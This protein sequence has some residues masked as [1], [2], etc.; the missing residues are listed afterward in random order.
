MIEKKNISSVEVAALVSEMQFLVGGKVSQ[1][2]QLNKKEFLLQLFA[3]NKG[4]KLLKIKSGKYF[5]FTNKK[6]APERPTGYCMLLRKHISNASIKEISQ[7]GSERIVVFTFERFLGDE[8]KIY[9][10]VVELFSR[11]NVIFTDDNWLILG[12]LGIERSTTRLVSS[13]KTFEFLE[14]SFDWK[15]VSEKEFSDTVLK[16]DKKNIATSLATDI[17]LGGVYAKELCARIKLDSTILISEITKDITNNLYNELLK[18][19]KE[20]TEPKGYIYDDSIS[21]ILL[22]D[23]KPNKILDTYS[24]VLDLIEPIV[25]K[26]PYQQKI[27]KI[28]NIIEKQE[29]AL[30]TIEESI[31]EN[32]IKAE[33]V[34]NF[35]SELKQL[36]DAVAELRKTKEWADIKTD[37]LEVKKIKSIDLKNKK[38]VL[39]M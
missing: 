25:A 32:T 27:K 6:D 30:K 3:R 9:Y 12:T 31:G 7:K 11:G 15:N 38:I 5:N 28:E 8:S 35:Y 16:S 22:F 14:A 29:G 20:I 1:I 18:I 26:S 19:R 2:Y 23:K 10:L 17:S 4:K 34:Y 21:P 39:D 24:D 13:Q 36:L 33:K 37:L